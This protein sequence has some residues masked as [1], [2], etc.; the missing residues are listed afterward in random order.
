MSGY[1]IFVMKTGGKL[2]SQLETIKIQINNIE[3]MKNIAVSATTS[4]NKLDST[5][6]TTLVSINGTIVDIPA[7][8]I[9]YNGAIDI[10]S[11]KSLSQ[12]V[13]GGISTISTQII[14]DANTTVDDFLN[15]CDVSLGILNDEFVKRQAIYSSILSMS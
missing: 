5:I 9:K 1:K 2:K 3:I 14:F 15:K 10:D 12:S 7:I 11:Y 8:D 13:V 6:N 4:D